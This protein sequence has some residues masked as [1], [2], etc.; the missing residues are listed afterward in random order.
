[1]P[2]NLSLQDIIKKQLEQFNIE[3]AVISDALN[4]AA[5]SPEETR[6]LL[7]RV[8]RDSVGAPGATTTRPMF[9]SQVATYRGNP[10]LPEARRE[11]GLTLLADAIL[12]TNPR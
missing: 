7:A 2:D 9:W 8:A 5:Q 6:R 4:F 10:T 1:M 3:P 12:E 11:M